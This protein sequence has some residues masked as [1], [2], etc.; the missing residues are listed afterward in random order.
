MKKTIYLLLFCVISTMS[1]S[2]GD[3]IYHRAKIWKGDMKRFAKQDS[4]EAPKSDK[5]V[6]FI[7]SSTFT[8]WGKIKTHFAGYNVLNR[9]FGGSSACDLLYYAEQIIFPY[10]PSQIVIYE[11]DNDINE[12]MTPDDFLI[13]IKA[14]VRLI[15]LRLPGVPVLILS[16]KSSPARNKLRPLYEEV[17]AKLYAYSLT[18]RHVTF[19]DT[20]SLL[21][22]SQGNYKTS[23]YEKD[24]LHI[25]E[26]AYLLWAERIKKHLFE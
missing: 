7:G 23:L 15:E 10:N 22:D 12:G 1:L 9:G 18:K 19:V 25:N 17:N 8:G 4:I 14:L 20:Y 2:A 16:V 3:S 6:L 13:D 21:L 24:M 5:L 26:A 11:G